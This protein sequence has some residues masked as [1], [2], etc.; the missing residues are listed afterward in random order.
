MAILAAVAISA[1]LGS[2]HAA[3][4]L[5]PSGDFLPS[6]TGP[7]NSGLDVVAHEARLAGDRLVFSG[8][9]AGA[10]APTQAI[11]GVYITGVDRGQGT[12]RFLTGTPVIGPHV[13]WDSVVRINPDGTGSF[14]NIIAGITTPLDPADISISGNDYVA[15]LPL[16]LLAFGATAPPQQW[17][18]NLWPRNGV[19]QNVQ[20]SDL[21]PD[22]GNSPVAPEPSPIALAAVATAGML[23]RARTRRPVRAP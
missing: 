5:D 20:V 23:A 1:L 4:I 19:G 18:Y 9:M 8:Q 10:I 16:S 22:D 3:P 21:A 11:G 14:V 15:N 12:A 6:Y 7:I 17:T 2:A 13:V